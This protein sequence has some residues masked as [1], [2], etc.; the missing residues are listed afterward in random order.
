MCER[1]YR[2]FTKGI[3]ILCDSMYLEICD[4]CKGILLILK[5]NTKAP[6]VYVVLCDLVEVVN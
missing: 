2:C 6:E 3:D 1:L 4:F 5:K